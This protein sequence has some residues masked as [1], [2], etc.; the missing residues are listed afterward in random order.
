MEPRKASTHTWDKLCTMSFLKSA[1]NFKHKTGKGKEQS[2][3]Q[4]ERQGMCGLV[5]GINEDERPRGFTQGTLY[6]AKW[7]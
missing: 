6:A 3:K 5:V 7:E 2:Q 1:S 4:F